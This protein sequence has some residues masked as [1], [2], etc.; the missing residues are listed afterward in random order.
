MH[1][2]AKQ[3]KT[4]QYNTKTES[5]HLI[6]LKICSVFLHTL[7]LVIPFFS[8]PSNPLSVLIFFFTIFTVHFFLCKI[9]SFLPVFLRKSPFSIQLRMPIWFFELLFWFLMLKNAFLFCCLDQAV[10]FFSFNSFWDISLCLCLLQLKL[11]SL[12]WLEIE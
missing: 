4:K 5:V 1:C 2:T 3:N 10:V 6:Y 7:F 11:C 8:F 12:Y 9:F